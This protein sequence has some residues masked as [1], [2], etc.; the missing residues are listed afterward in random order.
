[1]QQQQQQQQPYEAATEVPGEYLDIT[2]NRIRRKINW[3]LLIAMAVLLL[4]IGIM[5]A[6]VRAN[7]VLNTAN[8]A[9]TE[10]RTKLR[11]LGG[12]GAS[13][14]SSATSTG[15]ATGLSIDP[16]LTSLMLSSVPASKLPA[17]LQIFGC[18]ASSIPNKWFVLGD[19][20][21]RE[22][23]TNSSW[24][25]VL[26]TAVGVSAEQA[27]A[28]A[29][30]LNEQVVWLQGQLSSTNDSS[31]VFVSYGYQQLLASAIGDPRSHTLGQLSAQVFALYQTLATLSPSSRIVVIVPGIAYTPVP[32]FLPPNR[33]AC[34]DPLSASMYNSPSSLQ[35]QAQ[36]QQALIQ[37]ILPYALAALE[38]PS[39]RVNIALVD[40][41][42]SHS[43]TW[44]GSDSAYAN[45]CFSLNAGG[46]RLL[47]EYLGAC[48]LGQKFTLPEKLN[49]EI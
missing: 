35:T 36:I 47:G 43:F 31:V 46:Q 37:S 23:N 6:I 20:F 15:G 48:L 13:S 42:T 26:A 44:S 17:L 16:A 22:A 14:S 8:V 29:G 4:A 3:Q 9:V 24:H 21:V 32:F 11:A 38:I 41:L 33:H 18:S 1:M 30:S 39:L 28:P 27:V 25:Q 10:V 19:S 7:V 45:D 5:V 12:V 49:K 40:S 2:G 34:T